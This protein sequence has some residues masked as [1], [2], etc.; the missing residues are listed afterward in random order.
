MFDLFIIILNMSITASFTMLAVILLRLLLRKAPKWISY[1]LWSIVLF[2]LVCPFSFTSGL[3]L[4]GGIGVPAS[5]NGTIR[6]IPDNTAVPDIYPTVVNVTEAV[7]DPLPADG[8]QPAVRCPGSSGALTTI[9]PVLWLIGVAVML[10]CSILSYI[11]LKRRLSDATLFEGNVYETDAVKSPIV[12]GLIKPRIYLPVGLP[13]T[14]RGYVLLHE[15]THIM[16]RDYLAKPMAFLVLSIHWFNPLVWLSF[17]LISHDMEMSCDEMVIRK[18]DMKGRAGYSAALMRLAV[19][20]PIPA[21]SPLAFGESNAKKRIKN[22]LSYKKPT[23]LATAAAVITAIAA[24]VCLL[25]NPSYKFNPD[26]NSISSAKT[27]DFRFNYDEPYTREL[28]DVE[29]EELQS[30][31]S[32]V[33][34]M[35]RSN[36]YGGLTPLYFIDVVLDD[37]TCI[38]ICGYSHTGDM[39]DIRYNGRTYR[40]SDSDFASYVD[41]IC[42]GKNISKAIDISQTSPDTSSPNELQDTGIPGS[43]ITDDTGPS[44]KENETLRAD[45]P[46]GK[47]RAEAYGT[48]K[49]IT[50]GGLYPYEG[51]RIIRNADETVIWNGD[52]YYL[53]EFLWSSNSKYVAISGTARIYG[54]CFIVDADT[55]KVI[56]LPDADTLSAQMDAA[57]QP[58]SSRPDPYFMAAEWIND[59][60]IRV[61]YRWTAQEGENEVSGT[62]DYDTARGN[63]VSN[64]SKIG[65]PPG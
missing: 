24:A 55:G 26:K 38:K 63:I 40:F 10:I 57:S 5:E 9:L 6:Y 65:G 29:I 27:Y 13:E 14:D 3:S 59:T 60:T 56:E 46:D 30:R 53:V 58:A 51:V 49:G 43:D 2:R 19:R 17:R 36:K 37:G 64:T 41:R 31:L 52:G 54:V 32:M 15:R 22:I 42:A 35:R 12:C 20:R 28:S 34:G 4:L 21:G 7:S 62:Y 8:V 1:A 39:L 33:S 16:R 11:S 25:A 18:L 48:N 44:I 23:F 50:A 61:N 47:Y 45:S